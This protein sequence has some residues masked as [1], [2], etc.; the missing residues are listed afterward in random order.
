MSFN[1]APLEVGK[2]RKLSQG[3]KLS[4][5]SEHGTDFEPYSDPTG[6]PGS[7][8]DIMWKPSPRLYLAFL[9]LAVITM[10]VALDGTSLSVALPVSLLKSRTLEDATVADNPSPRSSPRTWEGPRSKLSGPA[11]LSSYAPP[12]FNPASP[13]SPISLAGSR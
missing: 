5:I 6:V 7:V 2:A 8:P 12:S 1:V 4:Y 3:R 11:L 10:M 13:A 9:T